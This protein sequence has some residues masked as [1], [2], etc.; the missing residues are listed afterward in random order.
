MGGRNDKLRRNLNAFLLVTLLFR[1][2]CGGLRGRLKKRD[3]LSVY[4]WLELKEGLKRDGA[5]SGWKG[6]EEEHSNQGN[7]QPDDHVNHQHMG[8]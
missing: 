8:N 2:G 5:Y 6:T 7:N 3:L 1:G 4:H